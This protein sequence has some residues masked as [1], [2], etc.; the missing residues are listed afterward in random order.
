MNT[1]AFFSM[2]ALNGIILSNEDKAYL[3]EQTR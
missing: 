2:I 1:D 3:K